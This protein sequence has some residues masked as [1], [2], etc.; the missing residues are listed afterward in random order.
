MTELLL[1][2]ELI[3]SQAGFHSTD[4]IDLS[5][6]YAT[7]ALLA[8]YYSDA[9]LQLVKVTEGQRIAKNPFLTPPGLKSTS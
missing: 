4:L 3:L 9:S 2:R 1:H 7:N 8:L 6:Y 5:H